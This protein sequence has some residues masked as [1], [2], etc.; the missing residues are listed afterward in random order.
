MRGDIAESYTIDA[1]RIEFKIRPGVMWRGNEKIGMEP[2]ELTAH[3]IAFTHNYFY[4]GK[5]T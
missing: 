2:R 5:D 3:D 4:E 1:S